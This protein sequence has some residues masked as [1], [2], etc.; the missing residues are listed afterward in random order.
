MLRPA[1][2]TQYSPRAGEDVYAE[3]EVTLIGKGGFAGI[4]S[5]FDRL[6]KLPR[7]S[8][9]RDVTI[10]VSHVADEYPMKLTLIIYFGLRDSS[11][12]MVQEVRRG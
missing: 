8:K 5:F 6:E 1:L 10:S 12:A 4:C 9:V 3:M 11:T 2:D 7:L